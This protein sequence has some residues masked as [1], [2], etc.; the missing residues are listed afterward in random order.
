[1]IK[2][3][4]K[5][6][7]FRDNAKN[8]LYLISESKEWKYGVSLLELIQSKKKLVNSEILIQ[9]L[10]EVLKFCLDQ[11]EQTTYE[12]TKQLV[13]GC[14]LDCCK[15]FS[16]ECGTVN[17]NNLNVELVVQCLRASPNPQT[18]HHALM[19]LSYLSAFI[20][21]SLAFYVF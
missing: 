16:T 5:L 6:Y 3:Q 10:F 13:L 8:Q 21:V 14:L 1:M 4:S 20:P 11:D 15:K 12:Y 18:H 7:N 9:P 17:E 19:L 2:V